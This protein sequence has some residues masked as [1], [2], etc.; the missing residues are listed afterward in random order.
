MQTTNNKD[1]LSNYTHPDATT[2]NYLPN[3]EFVNTEI[4]HYQSS[5]SSCPLV[6]HYIPNNDI[7]IVNEKQVNWCFYF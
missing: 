4:R 6:E 1:V 7:E 5:Y 2:E 3:V